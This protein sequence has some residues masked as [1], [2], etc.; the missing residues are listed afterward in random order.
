M[1]IYEEL[2]GWN[3]DLT[4]VTEQH[5]LPPQARDYLGFLAD[6]IGVPISFVGTGPGREQYVQF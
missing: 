2:P 5:Q 3:T 1:P 4:Q 6:Q